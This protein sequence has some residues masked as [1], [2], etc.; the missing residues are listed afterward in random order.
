MIQSLPIRERRQQTTIFTMLLQSGLLDEYLK[1]TN[2]FSFISGKA[3]TWEKESSNLKISRKPALRTLIVCSLVATIQVF[4]LLERF[5]KIYGKSEQGDHG[6]EE[7]DHDH[8][9]GYLDQM[10]NALSLYLFWGYLSASQF[11]LGDMLNY[12]ELETFVNRAVIFEKKYL[13][14][15]ECEF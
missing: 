14:E 2:Y 10:I 4:G 12:H 11:A 9:G 8:F 5:F 13:K 1:T 3:C 7:V 6:Y 15:F